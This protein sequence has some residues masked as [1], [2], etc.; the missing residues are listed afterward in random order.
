[1]SEQA[2]P[3]VSIV[4]PCL[5][6]ERYIKEAVE[7]V[8]AQDYPYVEHIVVDGASTDGTLEILANYAHLTVITE[9]DKGL[10]DALNK[11][12]GRANGELIGWLN[13]DDLYADNAFWKVVKAFRDAPSAELICGLSQIF[14]D[15]N[16]VEKVVA[17]RPFSESSAFSSG[18]IN[19]SAVL[20]NATFLTRALY[21]RVG[22]FDTSY[23]ISSDKD[24]LIRLAL[25]R[26]HTVTMGDLIYRYRQHEASLTVKS[27]Q[28]DTTAEHI[29]R[30]NL[31]LCNQY[32]RRQS[33]PE[34]ILGYCGRTYREYSVSLLRLHF[35]R[36]ERTRGMCVLGDLIQ[37]DPLAVLRYGAKYIGRKLVS[38]LRRTGS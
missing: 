33:L 7:S 31:R 18:Q 2:L 30:E 21:D 35:R 14:A 29:A 1:M 34:G 15:E 38:F 20:L 17:W 24:Y 27:V 6:A 19:H 32:L 16:G 23:K 37:R 26:P 25:M 5:N 4:T 28:D 8:L 13:A 36:G 12:I 9:P 10:Y 22:Q 11:G 3:K